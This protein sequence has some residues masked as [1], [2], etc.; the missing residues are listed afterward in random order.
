MVFSFGVL[1]E[2]VFFKYIKLKLCDVFL[3]KFIL[4]SNTK[5]Q[6]CVYSFQDFSKWRLTIKKRVILSLKMTR[7]TKFSHEFSLLCSYNFFTLCGHHNIE[8]KITQ[9]HVALKFLL[10]SYTL[11]FLL[12]SKDRSTYKKKKGF[13][14]G[15][16]LVSFFTL[17]PSL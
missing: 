10:G 16:K 8:Q 15:E 13:N 5:K 3:T 1:F 4:N 14:P 9:L 12:S 2:K 17:I 6:M 7:A 11:F